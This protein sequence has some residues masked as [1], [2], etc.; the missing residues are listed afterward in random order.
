MRPAV[1]SRGALQRA[2]F[3]DHDETVNGMQM[4]VREVY[5]RL[6]QLA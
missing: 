2:G 1:T 4:F 5:P 6:K 3:L